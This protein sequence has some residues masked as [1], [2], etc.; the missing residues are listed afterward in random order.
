MSAGVIK[1]LLRIEESLPFET[2]EDIAWKLPDGTLHRKYGPAYYRKEDG[3]EKWF[4]NGKLHRE[5]GP[6]DKLIDSHEFWYFQGNFHREDGP[7]AIHYLGDWVREEWWIHGRKL[8]LEEVDQRLDELFP[9][10][11]ELKEFI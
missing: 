9:E 11:K 3:Y 6:A 7:A 1:D 4:L 5:G 10:R 8:S 2:E